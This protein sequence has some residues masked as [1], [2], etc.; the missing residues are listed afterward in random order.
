MYLSEAFNTAALLFLNQG[1]LSGLFV[2]ASCP[3]VLLTKLIILNVARPEY[4]PDYKVVFTYRV[5]KLTALQC[6]MLPHLLQHES[7]RWTH[8]VKKKSTIFYSFILYLFVIL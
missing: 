5:T 3:S 4:K 8:R 2:W 6:F 1:A 7:Y